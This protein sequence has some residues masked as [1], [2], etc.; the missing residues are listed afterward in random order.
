MARGRLPFWHTKCT[1]RGV[2]LEQTNCLRSDMQSQIG[3]TFLSGAGRQRW[4]S[5]NAAQRLAQ[6]ADNPARALVQEEDR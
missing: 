3:Q 1:S 2:D 6:L 4:F 5:T